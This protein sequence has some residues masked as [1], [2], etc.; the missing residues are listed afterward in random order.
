MP[1][2]VCL[3]ARMDYVGAPAA[4]QARSF[5][6]RLQQLQPVAGVLFVGVNAVPTEDG[7][8]R[9]F[10][11][12]LGVKKGMVAGVALVQFTF[13][14]EIDQGLRFLVSAYQGVSGA[15]RDDDG[16][17]KAGTTPS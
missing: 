14:K 11:V 8:S 5:E 17:E 15:A 9:T 1:W 6:K 7:E 2:A 10:E 4:A 3:R 12:R 13:R 16:D